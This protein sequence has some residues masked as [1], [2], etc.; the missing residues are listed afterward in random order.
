VA[1]RRRQRA[2]DRCLSSSSDS[3]ED[4]QQ[5]VIVEEMDSIDEDLQAQVEQDLQFQVEMQLSEQRMAQHDAWWS[6][7][8]AKATERAAAA[9]L[10]SQRPVDSGGEE[11]GGEN[12]SSSLSRVSS[13]RYE[14]LEDEW[15]K[16]KGDSEVIKGGGSEVAQR[17]DSEVVAVRL[18]LQKGKRVQSK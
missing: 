12:V 5:N 3:G 14:G 18:R 11:D 1:N 9:R 2:R 16:A 15:W 10:L 8:L 4:L 17:G 13:S 6:N 7:E